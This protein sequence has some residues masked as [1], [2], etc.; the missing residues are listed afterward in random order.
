MANVAAKNWN[1][2]AIRYDQENNIIESFLKKI[3][4][5]GSI[6]FSLESCGV[7]SIACAIEAVGARWTT[8]LPTV[9]GRPIMGYGDLI[10]DYLNSPFVDPKHE[11]LS[12]PE[13]IPPNEIHENLAYS[14]GKV[15]TAKA[16]CHPPVEND[17]IFYYLKTF[18]QSGSAC[19]I[20]YLTDYGSGHYICIVAYDETTHELI[21]YDPWSKNKHCKNGGIM[22]RYKAD[23]I[24]ERA[25]QKIIEVW[26]D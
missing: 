2:P 12:R 25:R 4:A 16:K 21:G 7:E 20:S 26:N 5:A 19:V 10:F 13:T 15:S 18:V 1:N 3:R 23:F 24:N 6:A 14:V 11:H 8:P 9:D 17:L 22:E